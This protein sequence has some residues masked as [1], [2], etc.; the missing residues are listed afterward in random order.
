MT[1]ILTR[2][3]MHELLDAVL[4]ITDG[5]K[6]INGYPHVSMSVCNYGHPVVVY[7]MDNGFV[8]DSIYDLN[9]AICMGGAESDEK[10][11]KILEHLRGL[12]KERPH[13]AATSGTQTIK[14]TT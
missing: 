9:E 1:G 11:E 10:L 8:A 14:P 2:E 7:I 13:E 4:D 12:K 3:R 6:G 5:G